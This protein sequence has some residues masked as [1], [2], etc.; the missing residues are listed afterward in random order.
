MLISCI[1]VAN[2]DE[3]VKLR[4]SIYAGITRMGDFALGIMDAD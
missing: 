4:E 1:L 2:E 3:R